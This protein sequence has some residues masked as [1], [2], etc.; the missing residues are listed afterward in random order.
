MKTR[1]G[2]SFNP[3]IRNQDAWYYSWLSYQHIIELI[4]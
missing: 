2:V 1:T 4:E 3:K